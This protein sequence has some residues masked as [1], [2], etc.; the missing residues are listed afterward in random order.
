M[1]RTPVP[2][3]PEAIANRLATQLADS[4]FQ[5][6]D[7]TCR[8]LREALV[9]SIAETL[10]PSLQALLRPQFRNKPHVPREGDPKDV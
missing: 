10:L 6:D 1:P 5:L 9:E 2:H 7:E 8:L 4:L 3:S